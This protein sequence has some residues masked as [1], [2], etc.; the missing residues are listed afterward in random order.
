[1]ANLSRILSPSE[2]K[3]AMRAQLSDPV[4]DHCALVEQNLQLTNCKTKGT[5]RRQMVLKRAC[6]TC[7]AKKCTLVDLATLLA[8]LFFRRSRWLE[9]PRRDDDLF[10][11]SAHCTVHYSTGTR[12]PFVVLFR[13]VVSCPCPRVCRACRDD[14]KF[15]ACLAGGVRWHRRAAPVRSYAPLNPLESVASRS[16]GRFTA[17]RRQRSS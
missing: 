17:S 6:V 13:S 10:Y 16:I 1:M 3:E 7:A 15:S 11:G 8:A 2:R 14:A 12:L 4:A 9:L 5:Y